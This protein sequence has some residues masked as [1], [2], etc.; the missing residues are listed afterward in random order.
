MATRK[1]G[2][3]YYDEDDLEEDYDYDNDEYYEDYEDDYDYT[4]Y[5]KSG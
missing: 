3:K 1:G 4:G 2:K 5:S